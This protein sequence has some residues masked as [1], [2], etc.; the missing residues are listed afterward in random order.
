MS[1]A[2]LITCDV[3]GLVPGVIVCRH[4]VD[5][6]SKEW[7]PV[8]GGENNDWICPKCGDLYPNIPIDDLRSICMYH[9]RVMRDGC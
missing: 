1:D 6:E 4:L 7:R 8:T 9:A 3:H 2:E 5:G